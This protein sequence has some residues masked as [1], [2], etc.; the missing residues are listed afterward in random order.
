MVRGVSSDESWVQRLACNT[1][2]VDRTMVPSCAS[3]SRQHGHLQFDVQ[4]TQRLLTP[5]SS[6]DARAEAQ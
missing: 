4:N 3:W 5:K 6:L 2:R 1:C